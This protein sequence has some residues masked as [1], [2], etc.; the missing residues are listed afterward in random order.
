MEGKEQRDEYKKTKRQQLTLAVLDT[1]FGLD[2]SVSQD[3]ETEPVRYYK[4][5]LTYI[6]VN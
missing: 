5:T 6:M 1:S 2:R 4:F 3:M